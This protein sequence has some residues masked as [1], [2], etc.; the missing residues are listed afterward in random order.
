[1]EYYS[2]SADRQT[3]ILYSILN[4]GPKHSACYCCLYRLYPYVNRTGSLPSFHHD[5]ESEKLDALEDHHGYPFVRSWACSGFGSAGCR[6]DVLGVAVGILEQVESARGE[7]ASW[8]LVGFGVAYT[9]WGLRIGFRAS[10]HTHDHYHDEEAHAHPHHHLGHHVHIHGDLK[11]VTPWALF[12]I[13]V[14]GPCEPL[15]PILMFPAAQGSWGD[16]MWVTIAFWCYNNRN[17]DIHRRGN[18]QGVYSCK[19]W[20][21]RA[22]CPC[23]C[24]GDYCFIRIDDQTVRTIIFLPHFLK[25]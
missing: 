8:L 25:I 9:A 11:S 4:R 21:L 24:R 6:R 22:L 16:L 15:I 12:V 7:W 18:F 2:L 17:D 1:M 14:L 13:F 23:H 5:R 10:Q 3:S 20:I 19:F